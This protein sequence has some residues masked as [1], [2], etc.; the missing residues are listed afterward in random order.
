MFHQISRP[1]GWQRLRA[2]QTQRATKVREGST[3]LARSSITSRGILVCSCE[4]EISCFMCQC[5]VRA[6]QC[7]NWFIEFPKETLLFISLNVFFMQVYL[8]L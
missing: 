3:P 6:R 1:E 4:H 8:H 2:T 7:F 5:L